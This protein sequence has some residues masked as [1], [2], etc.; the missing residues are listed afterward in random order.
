MSK[1]NTLISFIRRALGMSEFAHDG[2]IHESAGDLSRLVKNGHAM[3]ADTIGLLNA[4][5]EFEPVSRRKEWLRL[6]RYRAAV[7]GLAKD[8]SRVFFPNNDHRHAA[9]VLTALV[10][11][12]KDIVRIYDLDLKGDISGENDFYQEFV[13]AIDRFVRNKGT[14]K[15]VVRDG[16][17]QK[18]EIYK[19]LRRLCVEFPDRVEVKEASPEY[20][21]KVLDALK[22]DL[23]FAIGDQKAFR[24]ET[25]N[26]TEEL[27]QAICSFN[28]PDYTSVLTSIFENDLMNTCN[29]LFK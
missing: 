13:P 29:S 5:Y 14:F 27:R 25:A 1:K 22:A 18:S 20:N 28:R 3:F 12:S 24:I 9:I 2:A 23:N 4:D 16:S 10:T 6:A 19:T 21:A 26:S 11:H 15:I 7:N 8:E 17:E